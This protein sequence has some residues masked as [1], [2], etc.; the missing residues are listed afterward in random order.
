[1]IVKPVREEATFPVA[2]N[3]SP[4]DVILFRE[5]PFAAFITDLGGA[6]SHTAIVARSMNIPAIVALHHA[7]TLIHEDEII[8]IDGPQGVWI[9]NPDAQALTEHGLQQ[10][11]PRDR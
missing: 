10:N 5:H 11:P 1:M 7:R 8:I 2:R 3:L 6:T 4:A 9:A